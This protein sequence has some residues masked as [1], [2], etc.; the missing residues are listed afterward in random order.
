MIDM[1][2]ECW[3][4]AKSSEIFKNVFSYWN[5]RNNNIWQITLDSYKVENKRT[6]SS[7][8]RY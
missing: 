4:V 6:L 5:V 2:H 8:S 3:S 7:I 1:T